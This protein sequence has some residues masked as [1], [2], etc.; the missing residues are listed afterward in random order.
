MGDA[1]DEEQPCIRCGD[2]ATVC[3]EQ[4][5][6]QRLLLQWR[7]GRLRDAENEGA[8]DCI[9]CGRC[10]VACPSRIPLLQ[11]YREVKASIDV[12]AEQRTTAMAARERYRA[13]QTRLGRDEGERTE[14]QAEH[15]ATAASADAVAAA[16]ARAQ[17]RRAAA[18]KEP[19]A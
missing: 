17:A 15:R 8:L 5:Q 2:C 6:P 16:I 14:R 7:E 4:L 11:R 12:A 9:E 1:S 18:R 19:G 10:D 3:P 13:R